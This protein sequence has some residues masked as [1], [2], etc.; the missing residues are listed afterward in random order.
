MSNPSWQLKWVLISQYI[1]L[2]IGL[3]L[4]SLEHVPSDGALIFLFTSPGL[5]RFPDTPG[6]QVVKPLPCQDY[7]L[8]G[9]SVF[10]VRIESAKIHSHRCSIRLLKMAPTTS[11]AKTLAD[12]MN[13]QLVKVG[14]DSFHLNLS[15]TAKKEVLREAVREAMNLNQDA[16]Y[17]YPPRARRGVGKSALVF[18]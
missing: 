1:G 7:V 10:F 11:T 4:L 18:S 6:T 12:L 14:N 3:R 9:Q 15:M 2:R 5:R 17:S 8:P 13:K 16:A